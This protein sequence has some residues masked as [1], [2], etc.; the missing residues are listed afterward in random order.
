MALFGDDREGRKSLFDSDDDDTEAQDFLS[1]SRIHRNNEGAN[2]SDMTTQGDDDDKPQ[3]N[4]GHHPPAYVEY[5]KQQQRQQQQD[6]TES[7]AAP[8]P[9]P[10]ARNT[11]NTAASPTSNSIEPQSSFDDPWNN[12]ANRAGQPMRAP[13]AILSPGVTPVAHSND[14][15]DYFADADQ[16]AVDVRYER[17]EDGV[18][19][20]R[21]RFFRSGKDFHCSS[22]LI[23][24]FILLDEDQE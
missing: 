18:A 6:L 13:T 7:S 1:S 16:I 23:I 20:S 24:V 4:G 22:T 21:C 14:V 15:P 12:T 8:R 10:T 5:S 2:K 19:D 9:A 17:I 3:S 11:T